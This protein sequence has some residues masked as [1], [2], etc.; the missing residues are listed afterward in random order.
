VLL[1][2]LT[3]NLSLSLSRWLYEDK[4][5]LINSC[6]N[7]NFSNTIWNCFVHSLPLDKTLLEWKMLAMSPGRS[8]QFLAAFLPEFYIYI[9]WIQIWIWIELNLFL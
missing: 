7:W 4:D 1:L 5:S 8:F 2:C 9:W 6:K 3:K